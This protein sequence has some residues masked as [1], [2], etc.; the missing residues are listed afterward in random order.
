VNG[1]AM[2]VR[3]CHPD[4]RTIDVFQ[5]HTHLSDDVWFHPSAPKSFRYSPQQYKVIV[6]R[7][8]DD[9]ATRFHTPYGV[10]IHPSNWVVFSEQQGRVLLQEARTKDIPIWSYDQWCDFWELRDGWR[11]QDLSW[12]NGTL[13]YHA[14]GAT[15]TNGAAGS[16]D[17]R[18]LVPAQFAGKA[19]ESVRVDG[20]PIEFQPV[21]RYGDPVV[22]VPQP[23]GSTECTIQVFYR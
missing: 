14:S 10:I 13:T 23:Q 16:G 12:K 3:F 5:Q 11:L 22:L 18:W 8:L 9:S 20:K 4:G 17:L 2:P 6:D 21:T 15:R 1:A 19:L 7:I